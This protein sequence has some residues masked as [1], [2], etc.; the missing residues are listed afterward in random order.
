MDKVASLV[1]LVDKSTSSPLTFAAKAAFARPAPISA[2]T[3]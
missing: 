3:S 2:A 1:I